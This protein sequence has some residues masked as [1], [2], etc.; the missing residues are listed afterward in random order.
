MDGNALH[1][2]SILNFYRINALH[3]NEEISDGV[4]VTVI[5]FLD[6]GLILVQPTFTNCQTTGCRETLLI[7]MTPGCWRETSSVVLRHWVVGSCVVLGVP[8]GSQTFG[9]SHQ[10]KPRSKPGFPVVWGHTQ[11]LS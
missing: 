9:F 11:G 6:S 3:C 4:C 2:A 10:T 7:V 1:C 8:G 5:W